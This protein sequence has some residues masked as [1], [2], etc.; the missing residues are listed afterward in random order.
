MPEESQTA[1]GFTPEAQLT[2]SDL[3]LLRVI[4]DPLRLRILELTVE[5][6]RTVKQI[7]ATLNIPA[8]KLYY[9]INT[10]EG[11]GLLK[12]AGTRLVSGILEKQYRAAALSFRFDRSLLGPTSAVKDQAI[13]VMLKSMTDLAIS[14]MD[15][16]RRAIAIG[17]IDF[18]DDAPPEHKMLSVRTLARMTPAQVDA[19]TGKLRALVD[20]FC[21]FEGIG[22]DLP[23]YSLSII[24]H[25]TQLSPPEEDEAT[26]S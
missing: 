21:D 13:E 8:T 6:P 4:A 12:V 9:H 10:L 16:I 20:E 7:A 11:S 24:F 15:N 22:S 18:S 19:F 26:D 17:L 3:D 14:D 2:I 23:A 1:E 25:P 5:H